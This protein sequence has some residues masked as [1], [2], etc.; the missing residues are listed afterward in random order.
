[1]DVKELI[2]Q[3]KTFDENQQ[4]VIHHNGMY[5]FKTIEGSLIGKPCVWL[6]ALGV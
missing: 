6:K 4:V 5:D 1:M 3:L 2:K